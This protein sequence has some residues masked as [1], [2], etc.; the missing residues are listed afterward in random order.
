[1]LRFYAFLFICRI[2]TYV[3]RH[4]G[5]EIVR[6]KTILHFIEKFNV[7]F[8]YLFIFYFILFIYFFL[9]IYLLLFFLYAGLKFPTQF[10]YKENLWILTL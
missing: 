4:Q 5:R 7:C 3:V 10:R 9:F 8:I 1:M 6:R 2:V